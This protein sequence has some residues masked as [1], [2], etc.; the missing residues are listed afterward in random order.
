[1][2]GW[3]VFSRRQHAVRKKE[4]KVVPLSLGGGGR[5]RRRVQEEDGLSMRL[6]WRKGFS[7]FRGFNSVAIF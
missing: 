4:Q 3:G 2:E 6:S 5:R 7:E 1:M